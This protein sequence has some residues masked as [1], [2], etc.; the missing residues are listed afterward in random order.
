MYCL[1]ADMATGISVAKL[2]HSD[3]KN[4]TIEQQISVSV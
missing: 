2:A 4:I 1:Y 3:D